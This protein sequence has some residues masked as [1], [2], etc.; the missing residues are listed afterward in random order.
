MPLANAVHKAG[1]LAKSILVLCSPGL[2]LSWVIP[3]KRRSICDKAIEPA[4]PNP[5]PTDR[6]DIWNGP[7]IKQPPTCRLLRLPPELRH[8]IFEM[9]VGNRLVHIELVLK[10][11]QLDRYIIQTTCYTPCERLGRPNLRDRAE[12]I[13]I[14]LLLTCRAIY[15]EAL[16]I[17]HRRNT[18]SFYLRDFPRVIECGLGEYC[19][20]EIRKIYFRQNSPAV[21]W[22]AA[23]E[24]LERMR[25]DT[26]T[27][28]FGT[29]DWDFLGASNTW[30]RCLFGLRH[31]R[32]LVIVFPGVPA[33]S[34]LKLERTRIAQ[35]FRALMIGFGA[36][37]E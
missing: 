36:Q 4:Y 1:Q 37:V 23:L 7:T 12:D 24:M 9:A 31:L 21:S 13:S 17:I 34:P 3:W 15:V 16:P 33:D 20:P 10:E 35:E 32:N 28:Q 14:A 30:G 18:F 19:L 25:L 11:P 29:D 26:L 8:I 2:A 22:H 27:L 6:I 5:L